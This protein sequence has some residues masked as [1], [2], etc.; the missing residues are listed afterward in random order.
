MIKNRG[1]TFAAELS[2]GVLEWL[3]LALVQL[4]LV[5]FVSEAALRSGLLRSV[6]LAS[7]FLSCNE[8]LYHL[9]SFLNV[10]RELMVAVAESSLRFGSVPVPLL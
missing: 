7:P 2:T 3:R 8:S 9:A 5:A 10:R 6:R 1:E 4:I